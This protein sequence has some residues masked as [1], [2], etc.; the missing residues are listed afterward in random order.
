LKIAV[1]CTG[2]GLVNRGV[3]TFLRGLMTRLT[4]AHEDWQFDVYTR[5]PSGIE[6]PGIR[7][8]HVAALSRYGRAAKIYSQ[9]GHRM[10]FYLRTPNNAEG[11][12]FA[13]SVAPRLMTRRYDLVFNQAGPFV[14]WVLS[15]RRRLGGPPF[16]QKTA[17]GYSPLELILKRQRPNLT[18][19]TSPFVEDWLKGE[20]PETPVTCIPNAVD[21]ERF[22]P[23]NGEGVVPSGLSGLEF[24]IVLFV[25]AMEPMKRPQ[26]AIEAVAK[27]HKGSLVMIGDGSIRSSV[28]AHGLERLGSS[29]FL[30]LDHVPHEDLPAYYG[31][32]DVFTLPSEEPFGIVFLESLA[33]NTPI[34]ANSSPVQSWIAGD[35]GLTCD[36]E[37]PEDYAAAIQCAVDTD[38]ADRPRIRAQAFD[39]RIIASEYDKA[40]LSIV[41]SRAGQH[42]P[43]VEA[44]VRRS[45]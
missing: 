17:S 28:A 24:P 45:R 22:S 21:C 16:A 13:L 41:E 27:L 18:I 19:A 15:I 20:P 42:S 37:N 40:F 35:S 44:A 5:A 2:Y 3:E 31:A 39:W 8:I 26:L 38:Y 7:L 23:L 43:V 9:I 11:L 6:R 36:C 32:A 14:G 4:E 12:S 25:G 1:M 34:V 29:R 10:G 33:C 30:S